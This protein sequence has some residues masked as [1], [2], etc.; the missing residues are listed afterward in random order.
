MKSLLVGR[1]SVA[2]KDQPRSISVPLLI[3]LCRWWLAAIGR[4]C[5]M[6]RAASGR[7]QPFRT[8]IVDPKEPVYIHY[9]R[10]HSPARLQIL[11]SKTLAFHNSRYR[12][13]H[14]EL[15]LSNHS[16]VASILSGLMMK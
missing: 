14:P 8:G 10:T 15:P 16:N 4:F 1:F 11:R 2:R 12:S 3:V 6:R 5:L 7:L 9:T 13:R